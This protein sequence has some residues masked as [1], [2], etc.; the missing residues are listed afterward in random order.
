MDGW[1]RSFGD[2]A[3][4]LRSRTT[5]RPPQVLLWDKLLL[6]LRTW[7]GPERE[8][9]Q[10]ATKAHFTLISLAGALRVAQS[11]VPSVAGGMGCSWGPSIRLRLHV[12]P[13]EKQGEVASRG[14]DPAV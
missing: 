14:Q 1:V 5:P 12:L 8:L 7:E 9:S 13:C 10:A 11:R 4:S 3:Y 6:S 2:Q